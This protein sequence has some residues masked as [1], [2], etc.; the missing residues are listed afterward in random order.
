MIFFCMN[1]D[2]I[3]PKNFWIWKDFHFWF[4]HN[5]ILEPWFPFVY[6]K[7]FETV[8]VCGMLRTKWM[9]INAVLAFKRD[10]LCILRFKSKRIDFNIFFCENKF[11]LYRFC[12]VMFYSFL[13]YFYSSFFVWM[14]LYR[15]CFSI[16]SC[17]WHK[18][19]F[20]KDRI[21]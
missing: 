19:P 3:W 8:I 10:I 14:F 1:N 12:F 13:Y 15:Q 5:L 6:W 9:V 2:W 16:L 20:M 17:L 21:E 7:S 11:V 18:S 4:W